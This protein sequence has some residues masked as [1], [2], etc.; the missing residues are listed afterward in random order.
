MADETRRSGGGFLYAVNGWCTPRNSVFEDI[1]QSA[2][3]GAGAIGVWEGKFQ[4]GGDDEIGAALEKHK[5]RAGIVMPHHWTIL[6]T[7]LDPGGM[8]QDWRTKCNGISKSIRRLAK[9]NPVGIMVGPGVSGDPAHR[10]GPVAHVIEGLKMVADAA[11]ESATGGLDTRMPNEGAPDLD[12]LANSFNEMADAVQARIEREARFVAAV[13]LTT[14]PTVFAPARSSWSSV[15]R[16]WT[17]RVL[18]RSTTSTVAS[19]CEATASASENS[20][21]GGVST[22]TSRTARSASSTVRN[23]RAPSTADGSSAASNKLRHSAV[24][25]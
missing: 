8:S 4:N 18:L 19:H 2:R 11:G 21:A 23:D 20:A 14:I 25:N 15:W 7:P 1:E 16:T 9:F 13:R 3:I 10:L 24:S 17:V 12:R 5:I 6:P 22:T